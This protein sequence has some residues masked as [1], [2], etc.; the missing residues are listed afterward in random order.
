MGWWDAG[1]GVFSD[2]ATEP[3]DATIGPVPTRRLAKDWALVLQSQAI[4]ARL[5]LRDDGWILLVD[6]AKEHA[7]LSAITTY[8][9]ENANWPPP[10]RQDSPRYAPSAVLPVAFVAL[11]LFFA[12]VTGP[13]S[14]N[15]GWF[16]RGAA[17][18]HLLWSEPWRMVTALTLHAD[19]KHVLGNLISGSIFGAAVSRRIGPGAALLAVLFSGFVGNAAN[20]LYH[21]GPGHRSIGASTAVFGAVG[22]LAALQVWANRGR[23]R[24]RR[25]IRWL[26][27]AGP[28]VG[29]LALLG[30]LGAGPQTDLW[31]HLFGFLAGVLVGALAGWIEHRRDP[32]P[33]S[34]WLQ[35]GLGA[36]AIAIVLACW[37]VA[38]L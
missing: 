34:R 11:A 35:L 31:A 21:L 15:A 25:P 3:Q 4:D 26:E 37:Q 33:S 9:Q 29:G 17:D 1:R 14:H 18:A 2:V 30:A 8:E 6:R 12:F 32:Y 10:K 22:L 20:A 16:R 27:I 24:E 5:L 19:G 38:V 23:P 36:A 13:A 7:A 28:V